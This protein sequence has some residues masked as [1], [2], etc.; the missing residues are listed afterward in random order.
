MLAANVMLDNGWLDFAS[1]QDA[2]TC[3]ATV[4]SATTRRA[5]AGA[6]HA[7]QRAKGAP[8]PSR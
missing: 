3:D 2:T 7:A 5:A 8:V 6:V 4:K 1:V